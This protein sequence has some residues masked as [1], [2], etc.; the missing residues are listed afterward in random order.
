MKVLETAIGWL[1]IGIARFVSGSVTRWVGCK[2]SS[3]QRIYYAN[4]SSHLDI[5]LL[6]ASLPSSVRC[7]VRPAAAKDYWGKTATRRFLALKIFNSIMID[8]VFEGMGPRAAL[9]SIDSAVT[10]L[11]E[12]YSLIIFP[13]GTRGDGEEVGK[14]RSG[15]YQIAKRIPGIELVPVYMENLN[16]I[17]PKGKVLPLPLLSNVTFGAPI[18]MR[19]G[20]NKAEFL[21]RLRYALLELKEV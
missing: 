17:L 14:F 18:Q 3:R 11:G 12:Q 13:E 16:R 9:Q 4:H 8:R 2:P 7:T 1:I 10:G 20:E 6:W 21:V 5:I 15:V 19:P